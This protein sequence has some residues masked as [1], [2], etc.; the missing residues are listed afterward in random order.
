MDTKRQFGGRALV[1]FLSLDSFLLF[2]S[3]GSHDDHHGSF[4][5]DCRCSPWEL[6]I[7]LLQLIAVLDI[8]HTAKSREMTWVLPLDINFF[9]LS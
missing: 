6:S 7:K 5:A 9:C 2:Q 3:E 4:P 1:L 8:S